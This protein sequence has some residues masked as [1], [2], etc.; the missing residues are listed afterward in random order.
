MNSMTGQDT[1]DHYSQIIPPLK[2]EEIL[3]FIFLFSVS[4]L[5]LKLSRFDVYELKSLVH[6]DFALK[7]FFF[8]SLPH[9]HSLIQS[10]FLLPTRCLSLNPTPG[11]ENQGLFTF[12]IGD[13]FPHGWE[14]ESVMCSAALKRKVPAN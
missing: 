3:K 5:P 4:Q 10:N 13:K 1:A 6:D 7:V 14:R 8:I 9:H 2:I 11:S 12:V